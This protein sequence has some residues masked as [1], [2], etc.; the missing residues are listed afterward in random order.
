MIMNF[1][2][3]KVTVTKAIKEYA[4][5]K[6]SKLNKYFEN[7]DNIEAHVLIKV[8]YN[9][10]TIEVTIPTNRYTLR[11]EV[12]HEDLCAAIDFV[13]DTLE[14]Q[15]RKTKAKKENQ[16]KSDSIRFSEA[17]KSDDSLDSEGEII[18]SIY[19]SIKPLTEEDAMLLLKSDIKNKFLPF[20]NVNTNKVNVVY[21]LKD[22]KNFGILE[23][24]K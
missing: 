21:K 20:I 14:G 23:Q 8:K 2:G 13:T 5:E 9:L 11:A 18:K 4:T 10:Q 19:Y 22:G 3:E 24:E 6:L 12:S 1:R 7:A 17:Q 15:I 16:N